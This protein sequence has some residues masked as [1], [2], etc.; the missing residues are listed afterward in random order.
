MDETG[1][2]VRVCTVCAIFVLFRPLK[3]RSFNLLCVSD[4]FFRTRAVNT[5][6]EFVFFPLPYSVWVAKVPSYSDDLPAQKRCLTCTSHGSTLASAI[7]SG[8]A[9][10]HLHTAVIVWVATRYPATARPSP[11]LENWLT[12]N[13]LAQAESMTCM[14]HDPN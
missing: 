4:L 10:F 7:P 5:V 9:I 8:R 1:R 13:I 2:N 14:S 12:A 6:L 3:K 11:V